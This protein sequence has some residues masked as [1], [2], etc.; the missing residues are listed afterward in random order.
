MPY[1]N[2]GFDGTSDWYK[3]NVFMRGM[4]HGSGFRR[5]LIAFGYRASYALFLTS[6]CVWNPSMYYAVASY[7][8]VRQL[9]DTLISPE[10][11]I[12]RALF[13]LVCGPRNQ[14]F[15]SSYFGRENWQLFCETRKKMLSVPPQWTPI[16]VFDFI[17]N[18]IAVCFIAAVPFLIWFGPQNTST[19]YKVLY[20]LVMYFLNRMVFFSPEYN[21]VLFVNMAQSLRRSAVVS[22]DDTTKFRIASEII[23]AY[24]RLNSSMETQRSCHVCKYNNYNAP[25]SYALKQAFSVFAHMI[26]HLFPEFTREDIRF[27]VELSDM[28]GRYNKAHG[29]VI[30]S[31]EFKNVVYEMQQLIHKNIRGGNLTVELSADAQI[32]TVGHMVLKANMQFY[33]AI[34]SVI[35]QHTRLLQDNAPYFTGFQP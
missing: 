16:K 17:M 30:S 29:Y 5:L 6:L 13:Y 24:H 23:W 31:D 11:N 34:N 25:E 32:M 8:L 10:V 18:W 7:T 33:T 28:F 21:N 2:Y 19:P 3:Y 1:I 22:D 20:V 15:H 9:L 4:E 14:L 35:A 26:A 12:F 27:M